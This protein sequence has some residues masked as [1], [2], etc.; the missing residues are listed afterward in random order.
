MQRRPGQGSAGV[1]A[2]QG[3]RSSW[4]GCTRRPGRAGHAGGTRRPGGAGHPLQP[5]RPSWPWH[6]AV[7]ALGTDWSC[8]TGFA[9]CTS[10]ASRAGG[11]SC[12]R[13]AGCTRRPG[14]PGRAD[15]T[16]RASR[17]SGTG[18]TGGTGRS[19]RARGTRWSCLT[20]CSRL[21]GRA[22]SPGRTGCAGRAGC[23]RR[24][25]CPGHNAC[26]AWTKPPGHRIETGRRVVRDRTAKARSQ[27]LATVLHSEALRRARGILDH[28]AAAARHGRRNIGRQGSQRYLKRAHGAGE[29]QGTRKAIHGDTH[30]R[31]STDTGLKDSRTDMD[32]AV[33]ASMRQETH[34]FTSCVSQR[35][36]AAQLAQGDEAYEEG[37]QE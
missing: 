31:S 30:F 29:I 33:S 2:E 24:T 28:K 37:Q 6:G 25:C 26:G 13:C 7:R 22:R 34:S 8:G 32:T 23:T 3:R 14:H 18:G 9:C 15:L 35:R 17:P 10:R 21:T 4:P 19:R 20:G 11:T 1:K 5:L 36:I 12:A 16:R 27:H